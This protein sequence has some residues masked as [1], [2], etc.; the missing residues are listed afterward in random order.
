MGLNATLTV[1]DTKSTTVNI[2]SYCVLSAVWLNA[3]VASVVMLNV[4]A[5]GDVALM[6]IFRFLNNRQKNIKYLLKSV[7]FWNN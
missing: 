3:V 5:S 7:H 2:A 4:V 1:N 6:T